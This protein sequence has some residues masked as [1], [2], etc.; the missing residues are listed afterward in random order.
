MVIITVIRDYS[1]WQPNQYYNPTA[2]SITNNSGLKNI[3]PASLRA[4]GI[5]AHDDNILY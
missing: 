2:E 5:S 3:K 1:H 4:V